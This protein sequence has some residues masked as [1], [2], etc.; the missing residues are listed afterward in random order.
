MGDGE[1]V[2]TERPFHIYQHRGKQSAQVKVAGLEA[3]HTMKAV[4]RIRAK[5]KT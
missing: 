5:F 4:D 1:S 3:E 2:T